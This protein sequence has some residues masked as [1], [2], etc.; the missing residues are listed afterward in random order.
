MST[1]STL[2]RVRQGLS[3]AATSYYLYT[4]AVASALVIH[5]AC[6][7][8]AKKLA[9]PV[10]VTSP[11]DQ[12][13]MDG[14]AATFSVS[15]QGEGL[16]YQWQREG[17]PI[18]S[19]TN[20]SWTLSSARFVGDQGAKVSV[21]VS[22]STGQVSSGAATLTVKAKPTVLSGPGDQVAPDGSGV[23]FRVLATGTGPFKYQWRRN[24]KDIPGASGESLVLPSTNF[25]QDHGATFDVA[26]TNGAGTVTTSA[27]ATLTVLAQLAVPGVLVDQ[28]AEDGAS[29]TFVA[30]PSG[31]GPF[32]F[33]W[34][35]EG[36]LLPGAE[37]A[38]YTI[39]TVVYGMDNL[40]RFSVMVTGPSGQ[41]FRSNEARLIVTPR[42]TV[43]EGLADAT[44]TDG[45]SHTWQVDVKGTGPF[46][47]QW[48][49]NGVAVGGGLGNKF[50]LA[51][52]TYSLDQGTTYSVDVINVVGKV[53][54][55]RTAALEVIPKTT[56]LAGPLA[57]S[58]QD[59][60]SVTFTASPTGTLPFTYQ[61]LRNGS[62]LKGATSNT[63]TLPA[64][65]YAAD[66]G[67]KFSVVVTNGASKSSTSS[68][69][70]LTVLPIKPSFVTHP[71]AGNP[72]LGTTTTLTCSVQ[73]TGPFT[74][75]WQ[76]DG[77]SL[78]GATGSSLNLSNLD[79]S[80]TGSYTVIATGP[81][82]STTSNSAALVV[83]TD[84]EITSQPQNQTVTAPDSPVFTV[85]GKAARTI[86]YQWKKDGVAIDG[87]KGATYTFGDFTDLKTVPG[88]Y[89]VVLNDGVMSL[90]SNS[91]TFKVVAPHPFY[92]P[93]G[94][95]IAKPAR[96]LTVLPSLCVDAEKFPASA[97]ILGYDESLKNPAWTAY[98]DFKIHT[99]FPN[100]GGDYKT[101][102]RLAFPQVGKGDMGTH[103]NT[104]YLTN[105]QGFD[106]GH[107]VMR[108]DVSYRYG[109][110]A[111]DYATY[112]SNLVPQVSYYNQ[113][114]W[115]DL[116]EAVGGKIITGGFNNGLSEIFGRVWIYSGPIFTG[117]TD[118]FI[119]S[120]NLYTKTPAT[121]PPNTLTI[122]MP[123]ACYKIMVAEPASGQ[124]L[125]RVMA[126]VSSNRPYGDAESADI[127]K[128]A[129]SVKRV[130]EM[131]GLDFFP[132]LPA[133]GTLDA[134]KANVDVRGWG[135]TFEKAS[136]PNV[137]MIK[138][139]WDYVPMTTNPI[140]KG[141][142]LAVG[143]PMAFEG[144]ATPN[145]SNGAATITEATW[146]FGDGATASGFTAN[147]AYAS[148]NTYTVTFTAKDS[149]ARTN[150]ISR[151]ITV[152]DPAGNLAPTISG[153]SNK[154]VRVGTTAPI[155]VTF[156][157]GD[158][159]T[160]AG[161]L[162][163]SVVSANHALVLDENILVTNTNGSI[164]L[165][166]TPEVGVIDNSTIT[167][168]V[169]DGLASTSKTFVF[170]VAAN[171][172]PVIAPDPLPAV[173]TT[174]GTV[175]NVAF[176]V[177]DDDVVTPAQ[178]TVTSD[179]QALLKDS[180]I[181]LVNTA[182]SCALALT[183]T[184][185]QVGTA[186]VTVTATDSDHAVT[187]KSFIL[188]VA[189]AGPTF[190]PSTLPNVST[191]PGVSKVVTFT[192]ADDVTPAGSI[193]V[194]ATSDNETLVK[195]GTG[196]TV[197]RNEGVISLTLTPEAGQT[198]TAT[199]QVTA[200][201]L[202]GAKTV[203][204]FT[205]TASIAPKLIISQYYEGGSNNKWLEVT[206]IGATTY[207]AAVRPINLWLWMN[208]YNATAG[209]Y[210]TIALTGTLAP[211]ASLVVRNSS[212]SLPVGYDFAGTL[213]ASGNLTFNGDDLVFL[214]EAVSGSNGPAAFASRSDVI[215]ENASSWTGATGTSN[216]PAYA[217]SMGCDR[218]YVR[219]KSVVSPNATFTTGEWTILDG[220]ALSTTN[221][222]LAYSAAK[223]TTNY[224]GFH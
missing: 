143:T 145:V 82:G 130:E 33:Q 31:T 69:A 42:A 23:T 24:E 202:D 211:G 3:G 70:L 49:R 191:D 108:S 97:F 154:T 138:P 98:A 12:V 168:T 184:A 141:D 32:K 65:I 73:G 121:L 11:T 15:A 51:T 129:T 78:D 223:G 185:G 39:P 6:G 188:T 64:T 124:T 149:D 224:L 4:M 205:L 136:G 103:G 46:Q 207:D 119:P 193:V 57:Q 125:P 2:F 195:N 37:G 164:R 88:S 169:T 217:K 110:A 213:I 196:I 212:A 142:T 13:V 85:A 134:W 104:F 14:E 221:L 63:Y 102:T 28:T 151:T 109:S 120:Q 182:G 8:D 58:V 50:R 176:T 29:A 66:N 54:S 99:N 113:K 123:T 171:S 100:G 116:E 68:E 219:S 214:S 61:W 220:A 76:K 156:S 89:T 157:V 77:S 127:W 204:S 86:T 107:M 96:P 10:I 83:T 7:G 45:S 91:V 208:P 117:A 38:R 84:L 87:A 9:A 139:S 44:V 172:A 180:D 158:D 209:T 148:A 186:Q 74:Y 80:H 17:S 105:G 128:Y 62:P 19:A 79:G 118:Y 95:P 36:V 101:D 181:A 115:N 34:I 60:A 41:S 160:A 1:H 215:G 201:D 199:I 25:A 112:M 93:A 159:T 146:T 71:S 144:A 90:E 147:H 59:G 178:V 189:Y 190:T 161:S 198:G 179:N 177:S 218:C 140:L 35:R 194:T 52:V 153:L 203:K 75:Q 173:S 197:Q 5:L 187:T 166:V 94:Q 27:K 56:V 47:Y 170:A 16:R 22:N 30:N 48:K 111:G 26:V 92:Q 53:T 183:P 81:G 165:D 216:T 40:A 167:V 43:V 72:A 152:V 222:G 126:W 133:G 155:P 20:A 114:L 206:N 18:P 122:A 21:L 162:G 210:S 174:P 150:S 132:D 175:K 200:E 135:A 137:H 55:S 131:T 192:V 67:A 106:R 163:V